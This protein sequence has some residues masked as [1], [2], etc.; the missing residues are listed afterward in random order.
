MRVIFCTGPD[1]NGLNHDPHMRQ[2]GK[3]LWPGCGNR[4]TATRELRRVHQPVPAVNRAALARGGVPLTLVAVDETQVLG[5]LCGPESLH[6]Q[7]VRF[8]LAIGAK[9]LPGNSFV[10]RR[11]LP[12][13]KRQQM[14]TG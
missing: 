4:C 12:A 7:G 5:V 8:I 9:E 1:T 11:H 3:G 10:P 13:R 14:I 2:R 6:I